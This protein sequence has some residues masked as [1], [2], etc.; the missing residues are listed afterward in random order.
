MLGIQTHPIKYSSELGDYVFF[1]IE[2]RFSPEL[3]YVN[4]PK[5]LTES[6]LKEINKQWNYCVENNKIEFEFEI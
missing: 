6:Q 5:Q 3:I 4:P 2:D 1:L